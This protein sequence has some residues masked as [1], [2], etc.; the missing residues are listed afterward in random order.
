MN[1]SRGYYYSGQFDYNELAT[2]CRYYKFTNVFDTQYVGLLITS[3]TGDQR[4]V[5]SSKFYLYY[6][7]NSIAELNNE[8]VNRDDLP[9]AISN[10]GIIVD[11]ILQLMMLFLMN[12]F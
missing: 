9:L 2:S 10:N 4:H 12:Q 11:Q 6:N 3:S 5:E 8:F 7:S 1:E